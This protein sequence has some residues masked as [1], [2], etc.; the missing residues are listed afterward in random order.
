MKNLNHDMVSLDVDNLLLRGSTLK[1]TEYVYGVVIFTG[2]DT[3]V[4]Q[5]QA[6]SKHK[7]SR[8]ERATNRAIAVILCV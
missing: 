5:N 6:K 2:H 1:N 7:L 4:M 3:K 8:L